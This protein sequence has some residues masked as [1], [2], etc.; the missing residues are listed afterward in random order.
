MG[1]YGIN[2]SGLF[3]VFTISRIIRRSWPELYIA[4]GLTNEFFLVKKIVV[5]GGVT[6]PVDTTVQKPAD[7][8]PMTL[9]FYGEALSPL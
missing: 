5:P 9:L 6:W 8:L 4:K 3:G 2:G 7:V 1:I